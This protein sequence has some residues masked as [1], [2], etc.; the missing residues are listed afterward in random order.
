[1]AS[2]AGVTARLRRRIERD[3]ALQGNAEEVEWIV[4]QARDSERIQAAIVLLAAGDLERL[5]DAVDLALI[6]SRDLLVAAELAHE[7]WA[8]RLD[9]CLGPTD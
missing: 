6:D 4:S 1:M 2:T 5:L 8:L 9:A 7:G 3:F